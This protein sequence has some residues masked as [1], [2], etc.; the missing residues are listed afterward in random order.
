M[1]IETTIEN[2]NNGLKEIRNSGGDVDGDSESGSVS[3]KGVEARFAFNGE[4]L[5]V[6]ID[7]TPFLVSESYVEDKIREYFI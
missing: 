4:I 3:I 5:T 7:S 6:A 1:K 2:V